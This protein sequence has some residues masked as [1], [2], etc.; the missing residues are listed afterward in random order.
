[1]IING[2]QLDYVVLSADEINSLCVETF[3]ARQTSVA[4]VLSRRELPLTLQWITTLKLGMHLVLPLFFWQSCF[5][6]RGLVSG[7]YKTE[8]RYFVFYQ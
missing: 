7:L 1:M 3:E 6:S 4:V 2:L 8:Y 5:T